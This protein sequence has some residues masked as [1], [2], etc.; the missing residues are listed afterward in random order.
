MSGAASSAWTTPRGPRYW[1]RAGKES[2]VGEF[3]SIGAPLTQ[4]DTATRAGDCLRVWRIDELVD[5]CWSYK[6][7]GEVIR[8]LRQFQA[9]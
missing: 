9:E 3:V 1:E 2:N 5:T 8:Q 4:H 7:D 6:A